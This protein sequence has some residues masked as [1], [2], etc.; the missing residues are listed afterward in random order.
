MAQ[1]DIGIIMNGVTGRMGTNQHLKRSLAAIREEG[2]I[3]L[4]NG[5]VIMPQPTLVGRNQA[6]LEALADAHDL[7]WTTDLDAELANSDNIIYFDAL[8]TD[9]RV[10][11][12]KKAIIAGKHIYCE[13]PTATTQKDAMDLYFVAVHAKVKHGVVQD[14]LWLPGLQKLKHVIDSGG[15][16]RILDVRG[17][18]GYWVAP[19][20][21]GSPLQR[22]S[23]NYRKEA[24][25]GIV[26]D[27][28]AHWRYVIDNLFGDIQDVYC[29]TA[30]HIPQRANEA[31]EPYDCDVDDAAYAVFTL[32]NG[33]VAQFNSSWN[34]RVRREDL[35]CVQV[36]GTEGSAYATL[37]EC[38]YQSKDNT[39]APVWNPDIPNPYNF[40]EEGWEEVEKDADYQNAFKTQWELF[41]RHVVADEP[42]RWDLREGA[43]G[44]QLAETAYKSADQGRKL[45]IAELP[46]YQAGGR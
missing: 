16:G 34:T 31:G 44:V 14:K 20:L 35:F 42:F 30:T 39:P 5:D 18:F 12:V 3:T 11:N 25:G 17:D 24:G 6:K 13:K 19:G 1:I 33:A 27:M 4:A 8:T 15:I 29:Q 28:L 9:L 26:L 40:M 7:R 32:A 46:T 22:P 21:D 2:G 43:K 38:Y 37:R 10:I 45:P 41:L 23:W 36:N